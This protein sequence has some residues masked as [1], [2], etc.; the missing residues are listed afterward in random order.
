LCKD[1]KNVVAA[2]PGKLTA[3]LSSDKLTLTITSTKSFAGIYRI[4][5]SSS[6][7][8]T[9]N[10]K[11]EEYNKD[12]SYIDTIAPY[13]VSTSYDDTGLVATINFSEALDI[14][15]LNVAATVVGSATVSNTTFSILNSKNNYVLS[16]DKKSLTI[17]MTNISTTDY[18]KPFYITIS[19]LKDLVGNAQTATSIAQLMVDTSAKP[20]AR[21]ISIA[22]TGLYTLTATFDRA[23]RTPGYIQ[24]AGSS[25]TIVGVVDQTDAKKVN[26]TISGVEV[27]NTGWKQVSIGWWSSYNAIPTDHSAEQLY[28]FSVNFTV[29]STCPVITNA[30][31]DSATSIL[32]LSCSENVKLTST[33]GTFTA[34]L[35]T[36]TEDI[37]NGQNITY[38]AVTHSLG[39]NIIKLKL[40]FTGTK[41]GTYAFT[42]PQAFAIDGYNNYS[43]AKTIA[44]SNSTGSTELPGPFD[45]RQ[46]SSN[47][48]EITLMFA[49]KLD[50]ASATNVANYKIQGVTVLAA[51]L[52]NN[53]VEGGA[54]VVLTVQSIDA[55]VERTVTISGVRGFGSSYTPIVAYSTSILFKENVAPVCS[56]TPIFDASSK[57]IIKLNFNEVVQGS[58]VAT[59]TQVYGGSSIVLTNTVTI[60]GNCAYITLSAPPI[61]NSYLRITIDSNNI[62][63]TAGNL[64]T[65]PTSLGVMAS[66]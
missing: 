45:I 49:N 6:I 8:T 55:T 40:T 51:T 19:G 27:Q 15:N 42:I 59:V 39:D 30:E 43:A 61:N 5:C 3:V 25:S 52:S 13:Y 31:F 28:P 17:N 56:A 65:Y 63:D 53:S 24:I 46:S 2:D 14:T 26:Y 20:Q 62:T 48:K 44:I 9:T 38:T 64:A 10:I 36:S 33:T 7:L 58:L 16:T 50:V 57:N 21:V 18:N 1:T 34:T 35:T 11:L 32:T 54:T 66:Y 37:F 4:K 47:L 22:R 12:V 60:S 29:E 41:T 23:I